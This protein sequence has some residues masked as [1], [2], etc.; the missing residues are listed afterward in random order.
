MADLAVAA[1][2]TASWELAFLKVPALIFILADNQAAVAKL[3]MNSA[4]RR[5]RDVE[6]RLYRGV[7]QNPSRQVR[8]IFQVSVSGIASIDRQS[9]YRIGSGRL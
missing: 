7:D 6:I 1:G 9:S 8:R 4:P 2:G 5:D 3:W